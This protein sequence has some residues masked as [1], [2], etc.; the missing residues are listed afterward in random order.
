[1]RRRQTTA[2]DYLQRRVTRS[3]ISST[4]L[5]SA[6]FFS[7]RHLRRSYSLS[8]YEARHTSRVHPLRDRCVHRL[9]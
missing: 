1:M 5:R 2:H 4:L 7:A 8:S 6:E 3:T 9:A